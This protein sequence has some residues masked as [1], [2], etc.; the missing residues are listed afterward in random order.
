[1]TLQDLNGFLLGASNL[2]LPPAAG[3]TAVAMLDEQVATANLALT[4][5]TGLG[6]SCWGVVRRHVELKCLGIGV[7]RRFPPRLLGSGV[8]V[9]GEVLGVRMTN[10]PT[11]G[12]T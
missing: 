12:E 3:A 9:V 10:F 6:A 5:A 11:G 1:M 7:R 4:L 2:C 8:E